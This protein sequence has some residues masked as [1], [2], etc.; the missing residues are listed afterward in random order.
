MA[1]RTAVHAAV[2]AIIL[3]ALAACS[4]ASNADRDTAT[5]QTVATEPPT[6]TTTNPYAVPAVIDAAYVN[7]VLAALDAA[8]G[9]VVRLVVGTRTISREAYDR[10]RAIYGTDQWLQL[11]LDNFQADVRN[12]FNG[13]RPSPGN[14]TS[15]IRRIVAANHQC[16][17]AEV[18]RDFSAVSPIP[19]PVNPQ[20]VGLKP[21]DPNRD[22]ARYNT[23][24]WAFIYD[25]F[26]PSRSQPPNPCAT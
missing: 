11:S 16:I 21:L 26:P 12:G 22:P 5:A 1:R 24:G 15:T 25:G 7:R 23:T 8:M 17:F 20:W 6:T 13:Y 9:D 19:N 14:K 4:P 3:T 2:A 18:E 10:L